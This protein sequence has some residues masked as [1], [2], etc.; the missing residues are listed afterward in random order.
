LGLS[1]ISPG[2]IFRERLVRDFKIYFSTFAATTEAVLHYEQEASLMT[3]GLA[4]TID[5]NSLAA[6][7]DRRSGNVLGT[8]FVFIK[9]GWVITAKHV[10]TEHGTWRQDLGL[11]FKDGSASAAGLYADPNVDLA[12]L[13]LDGSPCERP[14]FPAH[15]AFAGQTGLITA[16]YRPTKTREFGGPTIEI[17]NVPSFWSEQRDRSAGTEEV[18]YFDAQFSEGGHSGGPVF[19]SGGGVIGV[20]IENF[21]EGDRVIARATSIAPIVARLNFLKE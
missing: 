11:L 3:N 19:G 15:Q 10:V 9:P 7:I 20:V 12:V 17:N 18:I 5:S 16:G 4:F 21:R 2:N 13:Q 14:L 6:V 1:R 8:A